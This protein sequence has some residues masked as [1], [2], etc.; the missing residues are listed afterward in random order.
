MKKGYLGI[1]VLISCALTMSGVSAKMTKEAHQY[2]QQASVCEYK[3]DMTSAI[4][5]VKK[6][7]EVNNDDDVML[8]TKLGGLYSNIENYA[9]AI[10]AYKK[11]AELRPN[12]AFIYVSLG[13]IYQT[14][15]N[16]DKALAAYMLN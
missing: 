2:Y 13:S 1:A 10:N 14:V 8:Y 6:A 12:D 11:A 15:G 5:L 16:N 9:E 7:I 4:N 3:Q